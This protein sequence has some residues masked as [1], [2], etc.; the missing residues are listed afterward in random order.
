MNKTDRIKLLSDL[1]T[2][3]PDLRD[4]AIDKLDYGHT[5]DEIRQVIRDAMRVIDRD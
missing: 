5:P 2:I 1:G 4:W 3:C